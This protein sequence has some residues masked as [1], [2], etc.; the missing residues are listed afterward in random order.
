MSE[1]K[2]IFFDIDGTLEDQYCH[3][4]ESASSCIR[5]LKE[6]GHMVYV[7]SGRP[8]WQIHD[9]ILGTWVYHPG[10]V[11]SAG[12]YVE[13]NHVVKKDIQMNREQFV[14]LARY[15]E[16]DIGTVFLAENYRGELY[17]A[18]SIRK[19][20]RICRKRSGFCGDGSSGADRRTFRDFRGEKSSCV[21]R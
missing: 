11:A 16:M 3:I 8:M 12:A 5:K 18:V 4:P 6:K 14:Q 17:A 13:V 15:F 21:Q 9:Q 1:Q 7:A 2:I 19:K 20:Q 10:Y